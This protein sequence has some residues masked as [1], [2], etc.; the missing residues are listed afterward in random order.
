LA[1]E[2]EGLNQDAKEK[3]CAFYMIVI[4]FCINKG[5]QAICGEPECR[6]QH[7]HYCQ[8]PNSFAY[9]EKFKILKKINDNI[10]N[11]NLDS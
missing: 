11:W 7:W 10:N 1:Y 3:R 5:N 8:S 4:A 2:S 6:D 9:P